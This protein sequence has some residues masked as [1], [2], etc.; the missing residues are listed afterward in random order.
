MYSLSSNKQLNSHCTQK[1][2]F[3]SEQMSQK[4]CLQNVTDWKEILKQKDFSTDQIWAVIKNKGSQANTSILLPASKMFW[5]YINTK[6]HTYMHA[7]T[8]AFQNHVHRCLLSG[9]CSKWWI[10]PP[11][12]KKILSSQLAIDEISLIATTPVY[13]DESDVIMWQ[14]LIK[15]IKA[16]NASTY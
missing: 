11:F 10:K 2:L 9:T 6:A 8:E 5:G 1:S 14:I 4:F 16:Y 3:H 15:W 7:H 12:G 13:F